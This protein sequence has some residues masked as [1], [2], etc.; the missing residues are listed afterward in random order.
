[1]TVLVDGSTPAAVNRTG[2]TTPLT[3]AAFTPPAQSL[4]LV[5]AAAGWGPSGGNTMSCSDSGGHTFQNP[6]FLSPGSNPGGAV[7]IWYTYFDTSPGSITVSIAYGGFSTGGGEFLVPTVFTGAAKDQ[8][9]AGKGTIGRSTQTTGTIAITTTRIGSY[10]WGISDDSGQNSSYTLN[11]ATSLI[12][13]NQNTVDNVHMAAWAAAALTTIP[14]STTFGGT[15][16]VA[17][18]SNIAAFEVL[19]AIAAPRS[20]I[21]AKAVTRSHRY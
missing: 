4:L 20:F 2:T 3:C 11:G 15:W 21:A 1:M 10:V 12:S 19:P 17:D 5:M 8:S 6:C 18:S 13:D 7:G 14:G 16:G 9:Q